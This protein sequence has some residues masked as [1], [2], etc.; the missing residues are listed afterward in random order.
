MVSIKLY[1]FS[2]LVAYRLF[3]S[4]S[5]TQT[6]ILKSL[7]QF[8]LFFLQSRKFKKSKFFTNGNANQKSNKNHYY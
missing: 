1:A 3:V 6:I 4:R 2:K 8:G 7:N 5:I